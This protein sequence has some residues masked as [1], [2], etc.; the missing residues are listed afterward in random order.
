MM[1]QY[2]DDE[3]T[4]PMCAHHDATKHE[5]DHLNARQDVAAFMVSK[6]RINAAV[7]VVEL[8]VQTFV[9]LQVTL[10]LDSVIVTWLHDP[11]NACE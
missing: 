10:I 9:V 1:G 8:F 6:L 5:C 11:L 2:D 4:L 3:R 7:K